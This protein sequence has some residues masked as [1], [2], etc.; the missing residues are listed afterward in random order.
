MG[1]VHDFIQ[2]VKVANNFDAKNIFT[3]INIC[4]LEAHGEGYGQ[5]RSA[6]QE[7]EPVRCFTAPQ[8]NL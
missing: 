4:E 8:W 3:W 7:S 6:Q 2:N 5:V 1:T